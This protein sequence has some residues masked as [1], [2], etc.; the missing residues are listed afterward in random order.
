MH[1]PRAFEV[2]FE[3]MPKAIRRQA[4]TGMISVIEQN[5]HLEIS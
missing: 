2:S 5:D 1:I 4:A 3:P